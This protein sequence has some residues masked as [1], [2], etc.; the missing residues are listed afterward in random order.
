[1]L[2]V[3]KFFS[4]IVYT[5]LKDSKKPEKLRYSVINPRFCDEEAVKSYRYYR[6]R[7]SI[8]K[9]IFSFHASQQALP[10]VTMILGQNQ[11]LEVPHSD[12]R[13]VLDKDLYYHIP[14]PS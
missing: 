5:K 10:V 2:S 12:M 14:Y 4:V 1:M 3:P 6:L 7:Q 13:G 8:Q 11:I 9:R